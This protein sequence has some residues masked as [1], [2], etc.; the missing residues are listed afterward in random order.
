MKRDPSTSTSDRL[1]AHPMVALPLP[2]L[3]DREGD[4]VPLSLPPVIDAHVHLFPEPLFQAIW[5]WLDRWAWPIRYR[6]NAEA[7]VE[8]LLS[9]GLS[10]I[11]GLHYAHQPGIAR[12]LNHAMAGLCRR[13]PKVIG[14]ATVFP[15]E[16]DAAD[17]L[18][19]A[20]DM[21]LSGVKLHAHVQFF[22]LDSKDMHEVYRVCAAAGKPIVMHVGREP[23]SQVF[24]YPVD[25]YTI[26]AADKVEQVLRQYPEL[27]LCVPHLGADEFGE[28]RRLLETYDNIWLDVAMTQADYLPVSEP[29]PPLREFRLDRVM[30]GSDFP[31]IPYAWDRELKSIALQ[32]LSDADLERLLAANALEFFQ[33]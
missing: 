14:T 21:G 33:A 18:R 25:P 1:N 5:A 20:F 3:D 12:G 15:G 8:F 10:R 16:D 29:I 13:Y 17:I 6:L 28:Y 27:N 11:V 26:C 7:I 23:K 9:R 4:A 32:G 2:P 22:R 30:Y 24:P 19:E 31:H